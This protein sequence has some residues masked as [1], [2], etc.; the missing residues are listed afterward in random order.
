MCQW[1][2]VGYVNMHTLS[3]VFIDVLAKVTSAI[4]GM[5]VAT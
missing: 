1:Y 2:K 3:K 4:G 5:I